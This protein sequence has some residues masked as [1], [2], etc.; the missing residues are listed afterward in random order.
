MFRHITQLEKLEEQLK[1]QS[2]LTNAIVEYMGVSVRDLG[3]GVFEVIKPVPQ[4]GDYTDPILWREGDEVASGCWYYTDD[5]ELPHEAI[6]PGIP[7]G[8]YDKDF[9]DFVEEM[10]DE[11]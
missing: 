6:K 10:P 2:A 1:R 5:R 11:L 8:W 4:T 9:F 3:G 7:S